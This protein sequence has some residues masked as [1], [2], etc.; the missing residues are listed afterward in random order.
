MSASLHYK[1]FRLYSSET[2]QHNRPTEIHLLS[3][4]QNTASLSLTLS[5][6]SFFPVS[7][8]S[9]IIFLFIFFGERSREKK[10]K[11]FL[12][13]VLSK[14]GFLERVR[15][16]KIGEPCSLIRFP[17]LNGYRKHL[18]SSFPCST[19]VGLISSEPA[20]LPSFHFLLS[21][22]PLCY[23]QHEDWHG[24]SCPLKSSASKSW[25]GAQCWF[26]N[27]GSGSDSPV[28]LP[29]LFLDLTSYHRVAWWSG[30]LRELDY[31]FWWQL[32][33]LAP[34]SG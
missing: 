5:L 32:V 18:C 28:G 8:L 25:P 17:S 1:L 3:H 26:L 19:P 24:A 12:C 7:L 31:T 2:S 16:L 30:L 15:E 9:L 6:H 34:C 21:L 23:L 4:V 11:N 27:L 29:S 14:Y 22:L 20:D 33:L 10:R 13:L